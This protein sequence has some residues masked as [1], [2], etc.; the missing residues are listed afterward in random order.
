MTRPTRVRFVIAA[1]LLLFMAVSVA[2][3]SACGEVLFPLYR[4]AS[5][6]LMGVLAALTGWLPVSLCDF[7]LL[8]L[9][10]AA[11][12]TLAFTVVRRRPFLVWLSCVCVTVSAL[13]TLMVCGWALNHYAP[14]LSEEL[15]LDVG[16]Y[17][18]QE[19]YDATE[20]YWQQAAD[21]AV[22]V[23]RDPETNTLVRQD[24][25]QQA[26][27][28]GAA[29]ESLAAH[30]DAFDGSTVRVK[31]L[32]LLGD[33]LL[34]LGSDGIFVPVT[35][36]ANVPANCAVVTQEFNMCH[37]VAHRLGIAAEDEAN[38]AAFLACTLGGGAHDPNFVYSA[39]YRA[40]VAC[41]SA[42]ADNYPDALEALFT[43]EDLTLEKKLVIRDLLQVSDYYAMYDGP[44]SEAGQAVNDAY[45]KSFG[46]ESGTQSYGQWVDYLIA[47]HK[48]SSDLTKRVQ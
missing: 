35:G 22:Q 7:L 30:Y 40:F 1:A 36:E 23:Q 20:H 45:L 15:G 11:L 37:E 32:S 6:I 27:V 33:S 31:D 46:V 38:F 10:A 14:P 13:A 3:F 9:V 17:S 47:W 41:Y 44:A 2:L 28:A 16:E 24:F 18:A 43:S 12:I 21:W 29:Y 34:Y 8:I 4:H 48:A 5:R 39:Y 19:L 42:L 26:E 25:Q